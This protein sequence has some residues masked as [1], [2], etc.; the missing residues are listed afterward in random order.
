MTELKPVSYSSWDYDD[1]LYQAFLEE[2]QELLEDNDIVFGKTYHLHTYFSRFSHSFTFRH[3]VFDD[4][5][6]LFQLFIDHF[7]PCF[8]NLDIGI[9]QRNGK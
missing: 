6:D 8:F 5:E 3:I 7:G 2:A 1:D 4:T 9:L